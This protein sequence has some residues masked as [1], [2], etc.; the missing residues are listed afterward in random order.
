MHIKEIKLAVMIKF[1]HCGLDIVKQYVN[2]ITDAPTEEQELRLN[3]ILAL[4]RDYSIKEIE[5]MFL[6]LNE[7]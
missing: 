7:A 3:L 5:E 1:M 2:F 4:D 6:F